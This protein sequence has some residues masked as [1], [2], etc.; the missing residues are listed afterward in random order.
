MLETLSGP[1]GETDGLLEEQVQ[2]IQTS[3]Q[4]EAQQGLTTHKSRQLQVFT[5]H[6]ETRERLVCF[7]ALCPMTLVG[8]LEHAA[9]FDYSRKDACRSALRYV[10]A[11]TSR[12][13]RSAPM[14]VDGLQAMKV[15]ALLSDA[16]PD[17]FNGDTFYG[18]QQRFREQRTQENRTVG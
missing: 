11:R 6:I 12:E 13:D 10:G 4:H 18:R 9:H 17:L 8:H 15:K 5:I 1:S 3:G 7:V 16:Q 2:P 14:G